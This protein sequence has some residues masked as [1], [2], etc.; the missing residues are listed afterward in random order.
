[1]PAMV[2]GL[3]SQL[4]TSV[5]MRPRGR[6]PTRRTAANSMLTIIGKIMAQIST[7]TGRFTWAYSICARSAN[8][9]GIRL[10]SSVPISMASATHRLR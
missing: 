1:M 6:S 8:G 9:P 2:N 7:A 3:I 10:P 5:M 4:T